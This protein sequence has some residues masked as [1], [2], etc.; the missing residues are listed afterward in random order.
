MHLELDQDVVHV[1]ALH[2]E[3]AS[4]FQALQRFGHVKALLVDPLLSLVPQL[5][6]PA[7]GRDCS[8]STDRR[9]KPGA[10]RGAS[11]SR[12]SSRSFR[13]P[14]MIAR[15][16]IRTS[17]RGGGHGAGMGRDGPARKQDAG[18][19]PKDGQSTINK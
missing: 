9:T 12:Q 4:L 13:Q 1:V 16:L 7:Q 6:G 14:S 11:G 3:G 15:L 5:T 2:L 18:H 8:G 10:A 17:V 19:S